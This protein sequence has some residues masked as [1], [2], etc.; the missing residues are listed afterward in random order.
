MLQQATVAAPS[1][2]GSASASDSASDSASG[3]GSGEQLW[4]WLRLGWQQATATAAGFGGEQAGAAAVRRRAA[5][6]NGGRSE[7]RD[8]D[9][10]ANPNAPRSC[11]A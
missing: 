2:S 8:L 5:V 7:R 3:S 1:A 10:S 4:Q 11:R 9:G 6:A